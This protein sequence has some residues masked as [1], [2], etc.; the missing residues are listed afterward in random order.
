MP[1]VVQ[2]PSLAVQSRDDGQREAAA[3]SE[4]I[5]PLGAVEGCDSGADGIERCLRPACSKLLRTA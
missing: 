2:V 5:G 4:P 3:M 1:L